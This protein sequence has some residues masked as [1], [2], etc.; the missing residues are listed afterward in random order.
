M[1]S[2]QENSV[3]ENDSGFNLIQ[4]DSKE[5]LKLIP[6][7]QVKLVISSPPYNIGKE[8][9]TRKQFKQYLEELREV[10]KEL[11]RI[12]R[13]DGVVCWQVGNFISKEK[14][15]EVFPL[16]YYF[17]EIFEQEGFSYYDRIIWTFGH[18]L[19]AKKRLSGRYETMTVFRKKSSP[20]PQIN[21]NTSE[22]QAEI[23]EEIA[24]SWMK[25][26]WKFPNVK[27]NHVEKT[28]HPCQFP[29]E[30][31]E[32]AILHF[33]EKGDYVLDPY[34]GV[35]SVLIAA[36]KNERKAIGIE[37]E[38]KY[39]KISQERFNQ[40]QKDKLLI[41]SLLERNHIPTGREEITKVPAKF[42]RVRKDLRRQEIE[43]MQ[44]NLGKFQDWC[45]NNANDIYLK[46]DPN[47]ISLQDN[48]MDS[49][50]LFDNIG[51]LSQIK[52]S[53]FDLIVVN[54]LNITDTASIKQELLKIKLTS[55]TKDSSNIIVMTNHSNGPI[56][57]TDWPI[58]Y[59]LYIWL[60]DQKFQL[61]NRIISELD[62][63]SS[64]EASMNET[65]AV[66]LWFTKSNRYKWNLDAIRVPQ[67]YPGKKA[68]Q[69]KKIGEFSGNPKGKNPSD[70]W[71]KGLFDTITYGQ[72]NSS[73]SSIY[74]Q[75]IKAYS[76]VQNRILYFNYQQEM[77]FTRAA[78]LLDRKIIEVFSG[79]LNRNNLDRRIEFYKSAFDDD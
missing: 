52:N 35:S 63:D 18:G 30:L 57:N 50:I 14:W 37:I 74:Y 5:K 19:N 59:E 23:L 26:I 9:E 79:Q 24:N 68:Y 67:K 56:S 25:K 40:W 62:P 77:N 46:Q 29:I 2:F 38:E 3:I 15:S 41:R 72:R 64:K 53:Q 13:D 34:A 75:V 66:L 21:Q 71:E 48:N 16:D 49:P 60:K 73:I 44:R 7:K 65:F 47:S 58:D 51:Q 22:V 55:T 27:F 17:M 69:G 36:V 54:L 76:S 33:T 6:D 12:I 10:I 61:R 43:F 1:L 70:F 39:I 8:Y 28:E 78:I 4:G 42:K 20:F 31:V 11:K 32:R 45:L